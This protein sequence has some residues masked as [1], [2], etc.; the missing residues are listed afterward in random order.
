VAAAVLAGAAA[1]VAIGVWVARSPKEGSAPAAPR[2]TSS[3][4]VAAPVAPLLPAAS[5]RHP[6]SAGPVGL[7]PVTALTTEELGREWLAS[8][9]ALAGRL[10]PAVRSAIVRRRQEALDELERRDPDGFLRWLTTGPVLDRDPAPFVRGRRT[11]GE[12]AAGTDAT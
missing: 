6:A 8:T 9:T 5:R 1:V 2:P 7:P 11:A 3:G 4:N 12:S 10:E